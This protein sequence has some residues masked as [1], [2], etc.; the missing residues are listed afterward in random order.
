VPAFNKILSETG[1]D[2]EEFYQKCRQLAKKEPAERNRM[3][4]DYMRA[5]DR[6]ESAFFAFD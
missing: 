2:L 4:Q 6:N 1:A 3:L 5:S